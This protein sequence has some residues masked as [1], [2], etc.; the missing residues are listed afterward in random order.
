MSGIPEYDDHMKLLTIILLLAGCTKVSEEL[1]DS[2]SGPCENELTCFTPEAADSCEDCDATCQQD[3]LPSLDRRHLEGAVDYANLD[4][5]EHTEGDPVY[6]PAAGPHY[7][8]WWDWGVW[9]EEVPVE[10]WVHNMEHG[11]VVFLYNCPEGCADEVAALVDAVGSRDRVVV[12]P[13]ANMQWRFAAVAWEHRTLTQCLD[14]DHMVRFYTDRVGKGPEDVASMAPSGCMDDDTE[15]SS[16]SG[17]TDSGST[18]SGAADS[19]TSG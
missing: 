14:V 15:E 19:G 3:Y 8:C 6:P 4:A 10:R 7:R 5:V 17:S 9:E 16:D 11:G 2:S 18:D 12:S 1:A 13:Y